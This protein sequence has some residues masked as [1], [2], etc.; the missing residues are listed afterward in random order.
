MQIEIPVKPN[1]N[2]KI[3]FADTVVSFGGRSLR[4][5]EIVGVRFASRYTSGVVQVIPFATATGVVILRSASKR[6]KISIRNFR[7][8]PFEPSSVSNY[9]QICQQVMEKIVPFVLLR[10][11]REILGG[12]TIHIGRF[13]IDFNGVTFNLRVGGRRRATWDLSPEIR[14]T[15]KD[16]WYVAMTQSGILE[17]SYF[18]PPTGK[19]IVVGHVTSGDENGCVLSS[20][21]SF[22]NDLDKKRRAKYAAAADQANKPT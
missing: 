15:A 11:V 19:M 6:L 18:Y 3:V 9:S 10:L 14:A 4:Y 12:G 16:H 21:L 20:V 22:M 5:D 2:K 13:D 1:S 7:F 8:L 17:V